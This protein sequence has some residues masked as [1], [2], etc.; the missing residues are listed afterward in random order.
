MNNDSLQRFLFEN[1]NV[2]GELVHLDSAWRAVLERHHYPEIVRDVLGEMMAASALLAATIKFDGT[3]IMQ[4]RGNGPIA[5]MVVEYTS[6][7]RM[8]AMAHWEGDVPEGDL[9]T[10]FGDGNLVITIDQGENMERYQGIVALVGDSLA[11]AIDD[12]LERSEQLATRMWLVAN[13]SKAAGL[14]LQK[15]PG[16][17]RDEDDWHR[18]VTLGETV[19]NKELLELDSAEV[20]HRLFHEEDIRLFESEM[21]SFYCSCSRE[22]VE[23]M[24]RGL[25]EEE[26]HN[27]IVEEGVVEINCEFCNQYYSFDKVDAE[28]LFIEQVA[29]D[30]TSTKH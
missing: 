22:R 13:G 2:R 27:I 4:V 24:L 15:M 21:L 12:Y 30:I 6:P 3:M 29:P 5:M 14:L 25:G 19:T 7:G 23:I 8:R 28:Q 11:D 10:K 17:K 1:L 16:E 9:K 18:V 20:V 26:V